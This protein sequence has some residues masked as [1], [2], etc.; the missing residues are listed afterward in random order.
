MSDINPDNPLAAALQDGERILWRGGPDV[1]AG[2]KCFARNCCIRMAISLGGFL[3]CAVTICLLAPAAWE[4]ATLRWGAGIVVGWNIIMIALL[5]IMSRASKKS[6]QKSPVFYAITDSRIMIHRDGE[7]IE[8]DLNLLPHPVLVTYSK[9]TGL[10]AIRFGEYS[11]RSL[12]KRR[13]IFNFLSDAKQV[14][15]ILVEAR[16]KNQAANEAK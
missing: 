2:A 8:H 6:A 3:L 1:E 5:P 15:G 7:L 4:D 14:Y 13:V 9:K 16:E 10:G 11:K 12:R